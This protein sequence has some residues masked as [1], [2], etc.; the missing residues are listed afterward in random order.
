MA[1]PTEME[2]HP[3]WEFVPD[4]VMGGVSDG[5][6]SHETVHGR[7][8][9]VLRGDVSLENNGGFLQ[10]AFNLRADGTGLDASDW[11]GI[12]LDVCGNGETYDIRLRTDQLT[13][14]WQSFRASFQ[15]ADQWQSVRIRFDS[16]EA[17][18]TENAFDP[19]S[20]RRVGILAIGREFHAE[21]A[22]AGIRLYR[23]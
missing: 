1:E 2:L 21:I 16:V 12:E 23:D 10:I 19:R 18:R 13:R 6:M 14:P 20:L 22:V 17:H 8:A 7:E 9:V 11:D 15:T 4:G 3:D 5:G